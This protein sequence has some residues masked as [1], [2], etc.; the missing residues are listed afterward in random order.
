MTIEFFT[1][2][3]GSGKSWHALEMIMDTLYSG[4]HVIANFP[5]N[6]TD[7]MIKQGIHERFMFVP[8]EFLMGSKGMSFLYHVSAEEVFSENSLLVKQPRFLD[9]GESLCLVVIDEAGNYFPPDESSSYVQ[10]NWQLFFRQHR[11]LG[12]DF[13]LVSQGN[14]DIN[15]TIRSCVEYEIAHRKANRVAPF[16]W[17][18]WTIFFYVRY[19]TADRKRQLLGSESSIY[20]KRYAQ[21][22]NTH[23]LFGN[24]EERMDFDNTYIPQGLNLAFGNSIQTEVP[25]ENI[26]SESA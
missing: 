18:P 3:P 6:F 7:K 16:K 26:E 4:K 9:Q 22:Y 17:L 12:Y 14:S 21:L 1:G 11:K 15:R 19:W 24:F 13:L 10:K 2:T 8:D 23:K 20:V 25:D 5:L